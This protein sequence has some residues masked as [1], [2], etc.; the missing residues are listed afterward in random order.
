MHLEELI[1]GKDIIKSAQSETTTPNIKITNQVKLLQSTY[2]P[3]LVLSDVSNQPGP[4]AAAAWADEDDNDVIVDLKSTD[5]L[6]KL[7]LTQSDN[8]NQT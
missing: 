6:K 5:R 4:T 8:K 3:I 7:R 2:L 1:F